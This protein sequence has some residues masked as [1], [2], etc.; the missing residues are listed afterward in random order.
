LDQIQMLLSALLKLAR[1]W[2]IRFFRNRFLVL[3]RVAVLPT[4]RRSAL[5][6]PEPRASLPLHS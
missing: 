4:R 5:L 3:L 2:L 1:P 6:R